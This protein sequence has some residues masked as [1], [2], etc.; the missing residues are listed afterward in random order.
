MGRRPPALGGCIYQQPQPVQVNKCSWYVCYLCMWWAA[1][2]ASAKD[3]QV[4]TQRQWSTH[5][6]CKAGGWSERSHAPGQQTIFA[7]SPATQQLRASP[8]LGSS[9]VTMTAREKRGKKPK[10]STEA[11]G[12]KHDPVSLTVPSSCLSSAGGLI[13]DWRSQP[14]VAVP[15]LLLPAPLLQTKGQIRNQLR[16]RPV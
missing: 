16:S 13:W 2:S 14:A 15:F 4:V 9:A 12:D 3:L 10:Q 11:K 5:A 7:R 6:N 1:V 8:V